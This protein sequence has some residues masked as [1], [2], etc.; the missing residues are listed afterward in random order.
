MTKLT[1]LLF[2]TI[3]MA[4][5]DAD[6]HGLRVD[7]KREGSL[8][9]FEASFDTPLKRCDAYLY[10]TDYQAEKDMPG[11]VE[12][13]AYRQSANRVMV[14]R[15]LVERILFFD[16]QLHSV[17]EYTE[18]PF[19]SI[20]FT[21]LAGDSKSFRGSWAIEP[22]RQ[23][24]TLRFRGLWEPDTMIPLFIIDHFA[25]KGLIDKF[26]AIARLAEQRAG[27]RA[28]KGSEIQARGCAD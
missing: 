3:A 5:A 22:N 20:S 11:V 12:S 7:V 6:D 9:T 28:E 17:M 4:R 15:I 18:K 14:D 16:I 25:K 2:L 8:Y 27:S 24:S 19:D 13:L 26:N 21:Q 1:L 10:L 23:G